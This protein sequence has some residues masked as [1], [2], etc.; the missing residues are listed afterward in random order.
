AKNS[1]HHCQRAHCRHPPPRAGI[2]R[3]PVAPWSVS[4]LN[5]KNRYLGTCDL[6]SRGRIRTRKFVATS[7]DNIFFERVRKCA[8][9]D[10]E[11][12]EDRRE[13]GRRPLPFR[14]TV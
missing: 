7:L 6:G 9:S 14:L 3:A 11:G 12:E 1:F 4:A 8:F 2:A 10:G 5:K 13:E